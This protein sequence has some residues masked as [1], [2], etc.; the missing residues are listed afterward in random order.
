MASRAAADCVRCASTISNPHRLPDSARSALGRSLDHDRGAV[1]LLRRRLQHAGDRRQ[2][3]RAPPQVAVLDVAEHLLAG[4]RDLGQGGE[5]RVLR[6]EHELLALGQ[7]QYLHRLGDRERVLDLVAEHAL[8]RRARG[9]P[10]VAGTRERL[11][12]RVDAAPQL[13]CRRQAHP[14]PFHQPLAPGRERRP[15]TPVR[16]A[17]SP[18]PPTRRTV[19]QTPPPLAGE[20]PRAGS[21]ALPPRPCLLGPLG[22]R[23]LRYLACPKPGAERTGA[24]AAMTATPPRARDVLTQQEAQSRARRVSHISYEID[25][26]L[27]RGAKGYRGTTTVR[28]QRSGAAATF[29]DFRGKR[30]ERLEVNGEPLEPDWNGCRLTLPT[31]AL[32]AHNTVRVAYENDYDHGGDGFHQFV[33]P[34]DGEEYLY[35]NFEPYEAHRLFPCFDQPDIKATYTL[36]VNAPAQ[37]ELVSNSTTSTAEKLRDGRIR[38][39]FTSTPPFST[40]LFALIAGP[41]HVFRDR[42]DDLP[43]GFYCRKSLV[44]HVD[45]DELWEITKQGME[46]YSD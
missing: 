46:F 17:P 12:A 40:Y 5:R 44:K 38:H 10:L 15:R 30:I 23:S 7:A 20:E 18:P 29:L 34:E 21:G 11:V 27:T 8:R 6:L 43:L 37:W 32:A 35:T 25:L 2:V 16:P 9:R 41:Y 24:A 1:R 45:I 14:R 31:A 13:L 26:E 4:G 22:R 33:D 19:A 42:L 36:A 3:R 28:F 39:V